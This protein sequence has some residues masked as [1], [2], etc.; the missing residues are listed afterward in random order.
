VKNSRNGY[1]P[2]NPGS[3][4]PAGG[5]ES[6]YQFSQDLTAILNNHTI[7]FGGVYVRVLNDRSFGAYQNAVETLGA[8]NTQALNNFVT[9]Q[10]RQ[11]QSA[12]D[13]QGRFPG[14]TVT[15]PV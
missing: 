5:P 2:F 13:P 14:Q 3:A 10:L 12:I 1:L 11:F 7:K 15:L 9:G 4:I 6:N 8:S